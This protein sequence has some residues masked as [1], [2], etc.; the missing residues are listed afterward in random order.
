MSSDTLRDEMKNWYIEYLNEK[1]LDGTAIWD[2]CTEIVGRY[3]EEYKD[4]FAQKI[5]LSGWDK[6]SISSYK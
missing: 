4:P 6:N 5:E 2:K 3:A 1:G